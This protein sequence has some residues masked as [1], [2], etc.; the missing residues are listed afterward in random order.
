MLPQLLRTYQNHSL[1]SSRWQSF[2]PRPGDVIISTAY[3]SG[4]TWM[5]EIV[6]KLFTWEQGTAEPLESLWAEFR[7]SPMMLWKS[8]KLKPTAASSRPTYPSMAY[9]TFP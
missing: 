8:W 4:T 6:R 7:L 9:P 2:A 3:K 1:D 5:Q